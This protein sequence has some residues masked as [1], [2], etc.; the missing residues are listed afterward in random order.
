MSLTAS[1]DQRTD[2]PSDDRLPVTVL[3]GF[4]GSGKTTLLN[5]VLSNREGKRVAVIVNDM[6]EVN[7]DAQLI[8]DG[9]AHLDRV[10]ERLVE[11]SNGCI[12]CTLREDLL[13][14]VAELARAGRF[15]YLLIESTGISEPLPV[16]ETFV[17]TDEAGVSLSEIARLDTMVT[18]VDAA[19]FLHDYGTSDFLETRGIG[20]G[21]EDQRTIADLLVDQ[22]EFA[23][24]II[25]NKVDLVSE[26]ELE[27]LIAIL[28]GL[29]P[30]AEVLTTSY[31]NVS[32]DEV[33]DTG[34]FDFEEAAQAAGWMATMRGEENPETEEYG[35]SSFVWRARAPFHPERLHALLT[36]GWPQVLRMKGF[37]W[38]ASRPQ[39]ACEISKA[40]RMTG[41]RPVGYWWSAVEPSQ[42]P[43]DPAARSQIDSMMEEPWGD[44]RQEIVVIGIDLDEAAITA[45]LESCLLDAT[46]QAQ[47]FSG[48]RSLP[49]PFPAWG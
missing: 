21:P 11:M 23:D 44:R 8:A 16:A 36:K 19:A 30:K 41:Y 39:W 48:W 10:E 43:T 18:T 5:H 42:W 33:L 46:E 7:I 12:C 13:E 20:L 14:E 31:G 17:F 29:N 1:T 25:V 3:S 38:I 45:E 34:R 4:L 32:L 37:S 22:V 47:D 27:R 6:S 15:D 28:R 49:D 2:E 35:V 40:G 26:G 9:D 24:T